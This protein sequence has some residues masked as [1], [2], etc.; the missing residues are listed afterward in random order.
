MVIEQ[1]VFVG[2][3]YS[4]WC[5]CGWMLNHMVC[6][7]VENMTQCVFVGYGYSTLCVCG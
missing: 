2:E 7:W 5:V 3:G 1:C 6:L 4:T